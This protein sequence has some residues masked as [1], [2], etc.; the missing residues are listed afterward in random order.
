MAIQVPASL[1]S[2]SKPGRPTSNGNNTLCPSESPLDQIRRGWRITLQA[3]GASINSTRLG[4][5]AQ[6]AGE[7]TPQRAPVGISAIRISHLSR[8]MKRKGALRLWN[9]YYLSIGA[10]GW[11]RSQPAG[12][13]C[14]GGESNGV[15]IRVDCFGFGWRGLRRLI[16]NYGYSVCI[17]YNVERI[18]KQSGGMI[19]GECTW[20]RTV[21]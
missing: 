1:R 2:P 15:W 3:L 11:A 13:D 7:A 4:L 9:A 8:E 12:R 21:E 6:R 16:G 17:W 18:M 20:C 5:T 14:A 10:L 19:L